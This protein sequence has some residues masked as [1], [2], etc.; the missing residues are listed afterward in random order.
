MGINVLGKLR[1]AGKGQIVRVYDGA[2][3]SPRD[4]ADAYNALLDEAGKWHGMIEDCHKMNK[5]ILG[6][7][8]KALDALLY[9]KT[10]L[11]ESNGQHK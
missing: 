5:E 7:L 1:Y 3:V 2:L 4:V 8:K 9:Y 6:T 10:K 11:E